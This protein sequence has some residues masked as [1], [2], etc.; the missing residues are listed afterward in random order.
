MSGVRSGSILRGKMPELD[1]L[2]GIACLLVLFFHGI[3]NRYVPEHLNAV[4]RMLVRVSAFGWTGVNL[5]FV[6]SGF[7][8]TGILI[9]TRQRSDYYRRF[10]IRRALRILP[11]YYAILVAV[12]VVWQAGLSDRPSSWAF[13]GLS[14]IYLANMTTLFGVAAPFGV[15][16]SLAVEEHF[17]L[18]W[19]A[20]VRHPRR[21]GCFC[22]SYGVCLA[23]LLLRIAA[24]RLGYNVFG[25]YTWLV[26]DGLAMGALLAV[27]VRHYHERRSLLWGIV[28]ITLGLAASCFLV[29]RV[30][31]RTLFG[32]ALHI[33]GINAFFSSVV[34]SAL[35]LVVRN[36]LPRAG[37]CRRHQLRRIF[38]SH[39]LL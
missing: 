15:L 12:A 17:Y 23:S 33:T 3:G 5:F 29:D 8:I 16:W 30:V 22:G 38:D 11:L 10:Y 28:L 34:I 1:S 18:L 19:P 31:G 13:L 14:S 9:E 26:C 7:L 39:A 6:L 36:P 32:G 2:R 35:L 21:R 20:F 27:C 24:F 4:E 37:M 25:Y